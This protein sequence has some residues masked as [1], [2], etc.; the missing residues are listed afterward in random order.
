[1]LT[2]LAIS[3]LPR[4]MI[5]RPRFLS[6][7]LTPSVCILSAFAVGSSGSGA[8]NSAVTL[9]P[10]SMDRAYGHWQELRD[11]N[12]D[13]PKADA[14]WRRESASTLPRLWTLK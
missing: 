8:A 5:H 10:D 12:Q 11:V 9:I 7:L 13:G 1:M 2:D 4:I 14:W 6:V 3:A